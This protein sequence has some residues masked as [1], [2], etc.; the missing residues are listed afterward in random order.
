MA[1]YTHGSITNCAACAKNTSVSA[2]RSPVSENNGSTS[3]N[4]DELTMPNDQASVE[5]YAAARSFCT[6]LGIEVPNANVM[7]AFVST[8]GAT[9][10]KYLTTG[11]ACV[12]GETVPYLTRPL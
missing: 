5:K 1:S 8:C 12:A 10:A 6:Q 3:A 9:C 11:T 4:W 7:T 2:S